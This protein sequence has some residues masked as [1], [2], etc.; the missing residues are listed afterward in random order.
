MGSDSAKVL[1]GEWVKQRYKEFILNSEEEQIL[2]SLSSIPW[3]GASKRNDIYAKKVSHSADHHIKFITKNEKPHTFVWQTNAQKLK[4]GVR[5]GIVKTYSVSGNVISVLGQY[6]IVAHER[7]MKG[8][9]SNSQALKLKLLDLYQDRFTALHAIES[10]VNKNT[11]DDEYKEAF[12]CYINELETQANSL[13]DYFDEVDCPGF[14]KRSIAQIKADIKDDIIEAQSYLSALQQETNLHSYNRSRGEDSILEFVRQRLLQGLYE[15]QGI[16]QDMTFSRTRYF[17]LTRGEMND[18]IEDARKVIDDYEADPRDAVTAKHHGIYSADPKE[19]IGYDFPQ[20]ALSPQRQ[21]QVITAISFIEGWDVLENKKGQNPFVGNDFGKEYLE[22]YHATRW[23]THRSVKAA[24]KSI[25]FFILNSV[26]GIF[27]STRSWIE[28]DWKNKNF[29][30]NAVRL[31]Q[32]LSPREPIWK[33]PVYFVRQIVYA[34]VDIFY[35]IRDFGA[36]LVI[37]MPEDLVNDWNSSK[38]LP[39]LDD[40][41]T[42]VTP[43]IQAITHQ[44][45]ERLEKILQRCGQVN[46]PVAPSIKLADIEYELSG[47]EFNDILNSMVRGT[48]GFSSVFT[49]HIYA[50]DPVGGLVFTAAYLV[51]AGVIFLPALSTSAFGSAFVNA[52]SNMSYAMA[53]SPFGAAVAGGSTLAEAAAMAW[54]GVLHGPTSM[55][56]N[57]LHEFLEDPLTIGAYASA[58]Y[59]LGYILANGIAGNPIPWLSEVLKEDLGTIPS[60]GYPIIGGK[61]AVIL[62]EILLAHAMHEHEQPD[63]LKHKEQGFENLSEEQKRTVDRF[64]LISWL[65]EHAKTLPKLEAKDKF[66]LVRQI[67]ALFSKKES[68]SFKKLF[69]P[70][71]PP[72]IAFQIF[73]IPLSYIPSVLRFILSFGLSFVA[74]IQDKPNP[75]NPIRESGFFLVEKI[76]KDLSRLIAVT[77]NIAFLVYSVSAAFIKMGAYLSIMAIGRVAGLFNVKPAHAIHRLFASVHQIMRL[78]G[79]FFYPARAMKGVFVAHPTDTIIKNEFSYIKLLQKLNQKKVPKEAEAGLKQNKTSSHPLFSKESKTDPVEEN[80]KLAQ[81]VTCI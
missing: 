18:F 11:T 39:S 52:I 42:R 3:I 73:A 41:L 43:I 4:E 51:G 20:H 74:W 31:Q 65:S 48:S 72:S 78:I 50:K 49:H 12:R 80:S 25:C 27:V 2:P 56:A 15:F 36:K 22:T 76:K 29:H 69:Y 58:A 54:D 10:L 35:G 60:T 67:E 46:N 14:D 16:N 45:K 26:K 21:R 34:F 8:L 68:N 61:I 59:A 62:Y 5:W 13:N 53:S 71:P 40:T 37:G 66:A 32:Y 75:M 1:L 7:A 38:N 23:R 17:A 30:L 55:A 81:S 19:L 63:L 6:R 28:E 57:A 47:G 70:E 44:E 77:T 24:F 64:K 9:V 79:E 33:K